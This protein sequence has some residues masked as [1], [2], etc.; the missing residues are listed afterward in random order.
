MP[1]Y[2]AAAGAFRSEGENGLKSYIER[3]GNNPNA[4]VDDI[5]GESY[6]HG[7]AREGNLALLQALLHLGADK[8][9]QAKRVEIIFPDVADNDEVGVSHERLVGSGMTALHIAAEQGHFLLVEYL[10]TQGANCNCQDSEGMTPLMKALDSLMLAG[11][12]K[13]NLLE[14]IVSYF[15]QNN[16]LDLE[17][18]DTQGNNILHYAASI[19]NTVV[20]EKMLG[21][22][23]Q[24]TLS[25]KTNFSLFLNANN[26]HGSTPLLRAIDSLLVEN[27]QCLLNLGAHP[28]AGLIETAALWRRILAGN[29]GLNANNLDKKSQVLKLFLIA[30]GCLP[31]FVEGVTENLL[32][33][34]ADRIDNIIKRDIVNLSKRKNAKVQALPITAHL[35]LLNV[36]PCLAIAA[37]DVLL[38]MASASVSDFDLESY[39][40][41]LLSEPNTIIIEFAK[42]KRD[43]KR[44]LVFVLTIYLLQMKIGTKKLAENVAALTELALKGQ[45]HSFNQRLTSLRKNDASEA[46]ELANFLF[47]M[48]QSPATEASVELLDAFDTDSQDEHGRTL[49]HCAAAAG[50]LPHVK[51]L[52]AKSRDLNIGDQ[53]RN[54]PLHLAAQ[55]GHVSVYYY[56]R[57]KG[58]D[59][60]KRNNV[61]QTPFQC[62]SLTNRLLLGMR[63]YAVELLIL[64]GLLLLLGTAAV[65]VFTPLAPT[66]VLS[67]PLSLGISKIELFGIAVGALC[68]LALITEGI[69]LLINHFTRSKI[70]SL[71]SQ[72][73]ASSIHS[74]LL[75][76]DLK[77]ADKSQET[78]GNYAFDCLGLGSRKKKATQNTSPAASPGQQPA[79]VM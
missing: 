50:N 11:E 70:K 24:R 65:L 27:I 61:Q 30:L 73:S 22:L 51:K 45:D 23:K 39:L 71:P 56:L 35:L 28:N 52:S 48:V 75:Q 43:S 25:T 41:R 53:E 63:I 4:L 60:R 67:F 47:E 77:L 9:L 16:A 72:A 38:S 79:N 69:S 46:I 6:L 40:N 68:T 62:L 78:L 26:G 19:P 57:G 7:A 49:L 18:V 66:S 5:T 17:K 29:V 42:L 15:A 37:S 33:L 2:Q 8:N 14:E 59:T 32:N 55:A 31:N 20:L 34:S 10:V 58:A 1:N 12:K 54:T 76:G 21:K 3:N 44:E 36:M 13:K 64:L 74:P